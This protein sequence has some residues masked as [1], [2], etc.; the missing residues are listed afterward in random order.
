M[1]NVQIII[2][3]NRQFTHTPTQTKHKTNRQ[4]FFKPQQMIYLIFATRIKLFFLNKKNYN[5]KRKHNNSKS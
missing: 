3:E 5:E 4:L 2:A 1:R